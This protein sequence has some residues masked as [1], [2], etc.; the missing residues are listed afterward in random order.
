MHKRIYIEK[1]TIL[2]ILFVLLPLSGF[3]E[4]TLELKMLVG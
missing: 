3:G 4:N 2:L 1:N